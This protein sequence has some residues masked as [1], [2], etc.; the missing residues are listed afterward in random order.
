[1]FF[2]ALSPD[3]VTWF[4]WYPTGPVSHFVDLHILVPPA[5]LDMP[6]LDDAVAKLVA[7]LRTI[8]EEDV[9]TNSGV[10]RGLLARA[11]RPGRLSHLEQPLWQFQ[12][13]LAHRLTGADV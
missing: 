5:S 6:G 7:A 8:Q 9:R 3:A 1:M 4:R 12:R 2:F 11:A 10:Q 13:Y